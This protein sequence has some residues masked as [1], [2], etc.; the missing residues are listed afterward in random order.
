MDSEVTKLATWDADNT[1]D[2]L[3]Q[4][5][6]EEYERLA[7]VGYQPEQIAMYYGIKKQDFMYYYMLL[8]SKLK[9]HYDRGILRHQAKEGQF[10]MNDAY[11]SATTAQRL[12]KLRKKIDFRTKVDQIIYGGF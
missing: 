7:S 11:F 4:I 9:Y 3:D 1:P 5:D 12:D 2:W 8:D 6:W 10:M